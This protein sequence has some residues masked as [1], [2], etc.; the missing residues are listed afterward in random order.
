LFL[1]GVDLVGYLKENPEANYCSSNG[2]G[3]LNEW[4]AVIWWFFSFWY[5]AIFRGLY[6]FCAVCL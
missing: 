6:F 4:I 2:K 1:L 5:S 3:G